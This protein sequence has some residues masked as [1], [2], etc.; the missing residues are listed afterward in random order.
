M[1][2]RW[3]IAGYPVRLGRGLG[4]IASLS[5]LHWYRYSQS[6]VVAG[7]TVSTPN[8]GTAGGQLEV[9]D[10]VLAP[11]A[12][13]PGF[14]NGQ[15]VLSF[16]GTQR[17]RSSL[18]PAA[19]TFL[20]NGSPSTVYRI[21][22]VP[23]LPVNSADFQGTTTNT[24]TGGVGLLS[25]IGINGST[26]AHRIGNGV[27]N[28]LVLSA[29]GGATSRVVASRAEVD[30]VGGRLW[31][32]G[33]LVAAAAYAAVVSAAAPAQTW[34]LPASAVLSPQNTFDAAEL[35]I[36]DRLLSDSE[37]QIVSAECQALYGVPV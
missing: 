33:V 37:N 27:A 31:R 23:A 5:P 29:V 14:F 28:A 30:S 36:F 15:A 22:R 19:F 34:S 11:P 26:V 2:V 3:K 17:M 12:A 32:N 8:W 4:S 25:N 6:L 7:S 20:T 10:G 1:D 24:L 21:S 13:V 35:L 16:A 18:L 9:T